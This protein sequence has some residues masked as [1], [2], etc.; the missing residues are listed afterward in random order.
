M[1]TIQ[2]K[3]IDSGRAGATSAKTFPEPY[4]AAKKGR[5]QREAVPYRIS[6]TKVRYERAARARIRRKKTSGTKK[7]ERVKENKYI[8][9]KKEE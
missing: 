2:L 4:S 1:P 3:S 9:I 6:P 5:E 7:R 8:Y